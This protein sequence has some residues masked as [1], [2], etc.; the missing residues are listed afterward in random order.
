MKRLRR[1]WA[2]LLSTFMNARRET[3]LAEEI[4]T[5]LQLQ[6]EDNVRLGLSPEEARR[7]AVL[8]LGGVES[9]KENYRA[10][11]GLPG[12]ASFARDVR[13]AIRSLRKNPAFTAAAVLSLALGIALNCAIF[14]V[15]NAVVFGSMPYGDSGRLVIIWQTLKSNDGNLQDPSV[16]DILDWEK[17][18]R[19]L[20]G[21][22]FAELFVDSGVL[23]ADGPAESAFGQGISPNLL[24][25]LGAQPALGRNFLSQGEEGIIISHDFWKRRFSGNSRILGKS[26][27]W[28]G[29]AV[30]IVG[31]LPPHFRIISDT[32]VDVWYCENPKSLLT[33]K[34]H[35]YTAIAR[36]KPGVTIKQA[37]AELEPIAAQLAKAYPDTN[38]GTGVRVASLREW[39]LEDTRKIMGL[40]LGAVGFVLLIA[41]ANVA[42]LLLARFGS[43]AGEFTVRASLGASRSRLVLQMLSESLVLALLGGITGYLTTG[44]VISV[45]KLLAPEWLAVLDV[46]NVDWRV[47]LFTFLIT[48]LTAVIFGAAPAYRVSQFNLSAYLKE[49]SRITLSK[50]SYRLRAGLVVTEIA[51]AIVLLAGTG[52]MIRTIWHLQAVDPGFDP[53]NVLTIETNL[54]DLKKYV[55]TI[56]PDTQK[57]SPAVDLFYADLLERAS[58]LPAVESAA[59]TSDLPDTGIQVR[60]FTVAGQPQPPEDKRPSI[61]YYEVSPQ[62]FRTMRTPVRLG[63]VF[64]SRDRAGVAWTTVVDET[65]AKRFFPS[66]NPIG[67]VIR[68]RYEP[69][70]VEEEQPRVIVGVVGNIRFWRRSRNAFPIAYAST[71]QQPD[72]FP[73]GRSSAH[74][75]RR[76]LLRT[77]SDLRSTLAALISAVKVIVAEEDKTVPVNRIK[78]LDELVAETELFTTYIARLLAVFGIIAVVLASVGIYGVMSY[79]VAERTSEIGIRMA[80]G[81]HRAHVVRMVL[82][83]SFTLVLAGIGIGVAAGVGLTRVMAGLLLFGVPPWDPATYATVAVVIAAVSG[84]ASY[85]PARRA[86]KL[87]PMLALRHP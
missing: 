49:A 31:V 59:Y 19:T 18:S 63:R 66:E 28:G 10:Q 71:L 23:M 55:N 14:S 80:L 39:F 43:R 22:G 56:P 13:Y 38:K 47:L 7:Q 69:Y 46:T 35:W 40:L 67:K 21:I 2:R 70:K 81:A 50:S 83:K 52:L 15:A 82:R 75:R 45:F 78:T 26:V 58:K 77:R 5:H 16:A 87:D 37:Q 8:K 4:E 85:L 17:A 20:E 60:T 76:L 74:L 30:T 61:G 33:R 73:D 72:T 44:W 53:S 42:N 65:F 64:D 54:Y 27:F 68:F 9:L 41:C 1:A 24:P 3:E 79:T 29:R 36:L 12:L 11:R 48:A 32:K 34:E 57:L 84:I 6:T 86:A 62:Y 51:L 25:I